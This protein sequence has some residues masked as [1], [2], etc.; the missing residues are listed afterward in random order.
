MI[1]LHSHIIFGVD[2]GAQDI[3]GAMEMIRA[4]LKTG[5]S[6]IVCTPHYISD[7]KF[8]AGLAENEEKLESLERKIKEEGL[9]IRLHPGSEIYYD[10]DTPGLVRDRKACTLNGSKYI[11]TEVPRQKMNYESLLNYIF[12]MEIAGYSV[13]LAHPERYDFIMEDPN[14]AAS[15]I[16]R[17]VLMQMNLL[18]LTGKYGDKIKKTAKTMLEHNMVHIAATD[19]HKKEHYEQAKTAIQVLKDLVDE[20]YV[21]NLIVENPKAILNNEMLY[22]EK[23]LKVRK[24]LLGFFK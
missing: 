8:S 15:L 7:S 12:Q 5:Y 13:I 14:R 10:S 23:P 11:L 19:A 18:S 24:G 9:R 17:D 3:S 1:D 21:N 22:P 6:H 20:K 4:A 2:D 16:K